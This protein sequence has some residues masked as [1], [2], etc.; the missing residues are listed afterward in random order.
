M[1]AAVGAPGSSHNVRMLEESLFFANVLP[2]GVLP[3]FKCPLVDYG[4][5]SLVNIEYSAFPRYSSLIKCY[6]KH[7]C[8]ISTICY[9]FPKL[10]MHMVYWKV[11]FVFCIKKRVVA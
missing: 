1:Y 5:I 10:K 2:G 8:V 3:D 4:D 6:D 7:E 9:E 11:N